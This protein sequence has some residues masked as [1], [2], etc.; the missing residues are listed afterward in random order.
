MARAME[1][2]VTRLPWMVANREVKE[3]FSQFGA[4]KKC[5][6]PF[7]KDTGFHKGTCW[8]SFISEN[9]FRNALQREEHVIEGVKLDVRVNRSFKTDLTD[10]NGA[11]SEV[12]GA[13]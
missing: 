12:D 13:H 4:I 6:L 2:F 11:T 8:I 1:L 9:S 5:Y 3:Y 7:N 10:P